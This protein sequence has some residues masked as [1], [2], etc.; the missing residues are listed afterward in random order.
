MTVT[1]K[2][3]SDDDLY[4]YISAC[5]RKFTL[6]DEEPTLEMD[7]DGFRAS[8]SI[9]AVRQLFTYSQHVHAVCSITA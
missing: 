3:K 2:P 1:A 6:S 9:S 7:A 4:S 8:L 5:M